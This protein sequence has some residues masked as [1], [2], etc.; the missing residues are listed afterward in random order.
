M[1]I[2]S[3]LSFIIV[4]AVLF[5]ACKKSN[6]IGKLIPKDA[7]VVFHVDGKSILSKISWNDIKNNPL[8][9]DSADINALP[10]S[11]KKILEN[12]DS[13]GIDTK[14]DLVFFMMKDTSGSYLGFEG[15]IKDAATFKAF[16]TQ[17]I[18]KGTA[19]ES[20]GLN[21]IS[22]NPISLGWSKDK[23]VYVFDLP[24]M[25][26]SAKDSDEMN[27]DSKPSATRDMAAICKSIF[28]LKE[29]NSLAV[30][31][32][33]TNLLSESGD[34]HFWMNAE[35][36][37]KDM[38]NN[39]P[40]MAMINLEKLYKGSVTTGT[41]NFDN[42]KININFSSY[43]GEEITKLYKKYSGGKI[44]EDMINR[45]PSKN[46]DVFMAMNFK[47]EGLREFLKLLNLDGLLNIGLTSLGFGMDDFIK[48]NKGDILFA[49]SD[50]K[51]VADTTQL[52]ETE[53]PVVNVFST[54][55]DFN[56]IFS[57]SVGDKNAFNKLINAGK[58]AGGAFLS[59]KNSTIAYQSNDTYF[60]I[61][62]TK[63][64][65]DNYFAG[66]NTNAALL[67]KISGSSF[68][69]YVNIQSLLKAFETEAS[70]DSSGK[71]IYDA[72]VKLWDNITIKGGELK[73]NAI[74]QTFEINL[75]D[76]STNSLQ[77]L[78]QYAIKLSEIIIAKQ[79]KQKEDMMAFEDAMPIPPT[80][81]VKEK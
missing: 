67:S 80:A 36:L 1:K 25:Q 28:L 15:N 44:N 8:L 60:A 6:T 33:F 32:R 34:F 51:M 63:A 56:Y 7:A 71:V 39:N 26:Q 42:G 76:K 72:S 17:L 70:K 9:K 46:V 55:P 31:E 24:Q 69:G 50:F 35:S 10:A 21:F 49:V 62:N 4:V 65:V 27:T 43:A 53:T 66:G 68:G 74:T 38:F 14:S 3:K 23:F 59:E 73:N 61:G 75:V 77:Q 78:N 64:T 40:A 13:T 41:A 54:K 16:N 81:T 48:A 58:K 79:K 57:A 18:E 47:P 22:K 19:S 30:D 5:T 2:I 45:L 37:Y 11:L 52:P 12:P 20:D 29:N